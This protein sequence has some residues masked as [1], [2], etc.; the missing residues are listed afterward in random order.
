VETPLS[1]SFVNPISSRAEP[2]QLLVEAIED[3]QQ[4]VDIAVYN[5]SL[6]DISDALLAADQRGVR[7]RLVM[8]SDNLDSDA[9]QSLLDA[10]IPVLGD[11]R[12]SLMHNKFMVVDGQEVWTGSMNY[13]PNGAR[14]D[15]NDLIHLVSRDV[16]QDYT[17]E[18]EEMFTQDQ[19]GAGSPA[20]TPY[21]E[22][23]LS[24]GTRVEIY[25]APEDQVADRL[26]ELI[27]SATQ[28][29]TVLAYNWTSNPLADALVE[30][31]ENG[32]QVR[33]VMDGK[34]AANS[35]GSD[36]ER[37]QQSGMDVRVWRSDGLMHMKAIIVDGKIVATGSYNYTASADQKNDE[38]VVIIH[39]PQLAE[40][41]LAEFERID[42]I[43]EP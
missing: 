37:F 40:Q 17:A 21:P 35:T 30:Q 4:S 14:L 41:Y 11:R 38:N 6:E 32:L 23:T 33:M 7:V 15:R 22:T 2:E 36:L 27:R 1:V 34:T 25:F 31:A 39:Q 13:T 24:D 18:F 9:V 16:A 19:F 10:K 43:A 42:Q 5:L 28:S 29:I 26:A 20:N 8:E 12:E 3:A